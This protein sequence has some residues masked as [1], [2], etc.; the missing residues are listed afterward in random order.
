MLSGE[1]AAGK[2]PVLTLQTMARIAEEFT[3]KHI[4]YEQALRGAEFQ[5][6]NILDA[7]SHAVCGMSIDIGREG[8]VVCSISRH[9]GAHGQRASA[10][11]R[12][13]SA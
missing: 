7:I 13:S 10:P 5:I 2:Y 1:T 12:T 4:H 9:D 3:E 11:R 6:R 8:I